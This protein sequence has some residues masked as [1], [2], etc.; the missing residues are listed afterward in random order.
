[1]KENICEISQPGTSDA[2]DSTPPKKKKKK[3]KKKRLTLGEML[4]VILRPFKIRGGGGRIIP[5]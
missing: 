5:A 4:K 3:K 1:M 2:G